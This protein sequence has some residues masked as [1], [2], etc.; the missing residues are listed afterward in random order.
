MASF[1]RRRPRESRRLGPPR[2]E[3]GGRP[4]IQ[5]LGPKGRGLLL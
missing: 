4:P 5:R 2:R 3:R 1:F